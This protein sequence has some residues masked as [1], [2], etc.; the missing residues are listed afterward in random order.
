MMA[1]GLKRTGTDRKVPNTHGNQ[2][3]GEHMDQGQRMRPGR[4]APRAASVNIWFSLSGRGAST[5][6]CVQTG[7]DRRLADHPDQG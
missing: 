5:G 1:D 2:D 3:D 7:A 6:K 4:L